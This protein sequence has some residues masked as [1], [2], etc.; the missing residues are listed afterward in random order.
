M[1]EKP[2]KK[3]GGQNASWVRWIWPQSDALRL[4]MGWDEEDV[5]KP[6]ILVEDVFGESH[7]GSIHLDQLV[8]QIRDGIVSSGGRPASYHVTDICD[9]CAQGHDGMN[10]VLAQREAIADMVQ[11]HGSVHPWDGLV[12][13]SSCDKSIPA[14][15]IA[16][17]RLKLPT[18]FVPGGS[19]RPG[20]Y[21]TDAG[22]GGA[23]ALG[24]RQGTMGEFE[25]GQ[26]VRTGCPSCGACQFMGTASTMQCMA[27]ALGLAPPGSALS[28]AT[29]N[30]I[31]RAARAA[32]HMVMSLRH[33]GVTAVDIMTRAAIRNAIMIHAA[34][35]GSTN[36][37]LHLPALAHALGIS[38]DISEFD[39]INRK[40]PHL[41]NIAPSGKY[42]SELFWFA[43]GVPR[44]QEMLSDMLDLEVMTVTGRTL[45][46]NLEMIRESGFYERGRGYLANYGVSN[47]EVIFPRDS[48]ES[49]G[50]VAVLKG[51]LAPE[52]AVVKYSAVAENM[53]YHVGPVRA[54]DSE[55][56]CNQAVV[57]QTIDPGSVL[58]IR[59]EGPRGSGMPEMFMTTEAI[60]NDSK[61][62]DSTVLITDGRFS[63]ATRGPCVGHVSPE[64]QAG[65]PIAF[66]QDGD[67]VEVNI[68]DRT[69]NIIGIN[70]KRE[71]PEKI[72]EIL[73]KRS[74]DFVPK[75]VTSRSGIFR[76]FSEHAASA[77]YG[78]YSD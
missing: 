17:A 78:A 8:S 55:E 14:H 1:T 16:A 27:E 34:I 54:F 39:E 77:V 50:S 38:L 49:F 41:C 66:V 57:E 13:V 74:K 56:K 53:R 75:D 68:P 9:G 58:I 73:K 47:D 46:E 69:L 3:T 59:Y 23:V 11:I 5:N 37:F 71:P 65:G 32:G 20:P 21:L 61:L 44:V 18:V 52:G 7:P 25:V 15:L 10:Y 28:P 64:A 26:Y 36:A 31:R 76:K 22:R 33:K 67:I 72:A 45:G 19:M 42:P 40:V 4:G 62:K 70:G 51:N 43:G 60:M 48:C 6:Y 24:R 63:G 35:G 12:L 29:M 30:D 2:D